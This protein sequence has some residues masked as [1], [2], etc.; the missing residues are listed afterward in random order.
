MTTFR[1]DGGA[2]ASSS[3]FSMRLEANG[4]EFAADVPGVDRRDA[5][6]CRS[7]RRDRLDHQPRKCPSGTERRRV[8]RAGPLFARPT[9][10]HDQRE[11]E[12]ADYPNESR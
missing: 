2:K 1:Q 9:E 6:D 10:Q 7:D 5:I 11:S 12:R 4:G 8:W 3:W